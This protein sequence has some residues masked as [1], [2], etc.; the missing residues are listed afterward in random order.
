[1]CS[2]RNNSVPAHIQNAG[3]SPSIGVPPQGAEL[4]TNPGILVQSCCQN[5]PMLDVDRMEGHGL[6]HRSGA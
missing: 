1:V 3:H 2:L 6:S 4:L 5:L